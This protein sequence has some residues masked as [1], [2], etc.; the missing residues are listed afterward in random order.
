MRFEEA[1]SHILSRQKSELPGH[2]LYHSHRHVLDVY[3]AAEAI[4]RAEGL[5]DHDLKLL[6]TAV[7]YHDAGFILSPVNHETYSCEL[8]RTELPEF[9]FESEDI[10]CICGMI[11]ATRVPQKPSNLL[12]EIICDA[13][14]D[15]LG[16]DDFFV[17][18]SQ[19]YQE[20]KDSL[21][22]QSEQEWNEMQIRF[23]ESHRYF[24]KTSVQ[25]RNA[26]KEA[27]LDAVRRKL[28]P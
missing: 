26:G 2:L 21:V 8:V 9:G 14:L 5:G 11:M 13:D 22:I 15:Y 1:K 19:L 4:G 10:E 28:Q 25:R 27:N 6:L 24:T 12:E 3:Q 7:C 20:L 17:I 16:R 23:L 18:G